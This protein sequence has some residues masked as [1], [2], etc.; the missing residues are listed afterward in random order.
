MSASLVGSEMCIR[1]RPKLS[2][3][4][5]VVQ[6]ACSVPPNAR[7]PLK[8]PP[9]QA[10]SSQLAAGSSPGGVSE[11]GGAYITP[12]VESGA[13]AEPPEASELSLIHI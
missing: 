12:E 10:G 7:P 4:K 1:D 5:D 8:A 6:R 3:R 11:A 13:A 9:K 2:P